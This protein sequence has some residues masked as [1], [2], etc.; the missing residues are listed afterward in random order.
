[1]HNLKQMALL[2]ESQYRYWLMLIILIQWARQQSV[3]RKHSLHS[4]M[5][6]RKWR[7]KTN[8]EKT[9]CMHVTKRSI[10]P[11]KIQIGS[12]NFETV[13]KFKHFGTTVTNGN[14]LATEL[15]IKIIL[16]NKCYHGFKAKFK[17]HFLTTSTKL[18]LYKMLLRPY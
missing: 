5:L 6:Q 14:S 4:Q 17:S 9:R 13:Q 3:L 10:K 15:S 7:L 16:A 12:C 2:I 8:E 1:M 18:R 11:Y